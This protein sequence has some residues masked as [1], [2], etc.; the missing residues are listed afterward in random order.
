MSKKW[1][2]WTPKERGD[3]DEEGRGTYEL[4]FE[5]DEKEEKEEVP[6]N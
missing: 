3:D 6:Q 5:E 2:S 1:F 4:G